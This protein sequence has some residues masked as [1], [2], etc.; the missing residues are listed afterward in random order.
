[1][2]LILVLI[3]SGLAWFQGHPLEGS[4]S[5]APPSGLA[6]NSGAKTLP[7]RPRD[8]RREFLVFDATS[9][10]LKPDL[11]R[12]GLKP[13]FMVAPA[14]IWPGD[15][16]SDPLPDKGLVR[17]AATR[18]AKTGG[19]AILDIEHWPL[20]GDPG[21]VD[22]SIRRYETLIRWF[23]KDAPSVKVGYY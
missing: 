4:D 23:K 6:Q 20:T 7:N 5:S 17:N 22:E 15:R 11:S 14:M 19:I 9:Y 3:S 18:A 21:V 2:R 12:Y 1:M 8:P 10:R 13:V 16:H